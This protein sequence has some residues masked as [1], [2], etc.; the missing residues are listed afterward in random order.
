MVSL[1]GVQV[2]SIRTVMPDNLV[3]DE[4]AQTRIYNEITLRYDKIQH[5]SGPTL[6]KIAT[7]TWFNQRGSGAG[8]G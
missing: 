6:N 3:T 5:F 4:S 7:S 1:V 8:D 2:I